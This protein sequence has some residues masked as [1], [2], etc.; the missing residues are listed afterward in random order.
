MSGDISFRTAM[1]AEKQ[2]WKINFRFCTTAEV[3]DEQETG[4]KQRMCD[5][6]EMGCVCVAKKRWW[7]WQFIHPCTLLYHFVFSSQL[8]FMQ[9]WNLYEL[10]EKP[11]KWSLRAHSYKVIRKETSKYDNEKM[12][13]ACTYCD[14]L[15]ETLRSR[16]NDTKTENDSLFVCLYL[17][18]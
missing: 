10:E 15:F 11:A 8:T 9:C 3:L 5:E 4:S 17:F 16:E 18:V 7:Q 14:A 12:I 13:T 6:S 2:I 1:W